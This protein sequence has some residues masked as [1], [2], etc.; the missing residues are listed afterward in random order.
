MS[1][2]L[3]ALIS[4]AMCVTHCVMAE[5]HNPLFFASSYCLRGCLL[6]VGV[7]CVTRTGLTSSL[8]SDKT[9]KQTNHGDEKI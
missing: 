7:C 5:K 6:D 4:L 9:C 1:V 8:P 3:H 2:S